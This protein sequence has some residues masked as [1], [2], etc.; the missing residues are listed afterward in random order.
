ME[1]WT[2]VYNHFFVIHRL[3]GYHSWIVCSEIANLKAFRGLHWWFFSLVGY[4]RIACKSPEAFLNV[5]H[6]TLVVTQSLVKFLY[7]RRQPCLSIIKT[8]ESNKYITCSHTWLYWW[9]ASKRLMDVGCCL[10]DQFMLHVMR[11]MQH[12]IFCSDNCLILRMM[13]WGP[14]LHWATLD[15]FNVWISATKIFLKYFLF[16]SPVMFRLAVLCRN[17]R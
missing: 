5:A 12:A 6:S 3:P 8:H 15:S 10:L 7:S 14:Y 11:I 16:Q 1:T 2:V 9:H 4:S 13:H 17:G